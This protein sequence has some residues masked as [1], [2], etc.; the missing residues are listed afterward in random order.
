MSS[1][2]V[3]IIPPGFWLCCNAAGQPVFRKFQIYAVVY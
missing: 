3:G 1:D 2:L